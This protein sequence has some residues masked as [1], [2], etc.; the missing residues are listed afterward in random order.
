MTGNDEHELTDE[1]FAKIVDEALR[2]FP[3]VYHDPDT[4]DADPFWTAMFILSLIA[5]W[6]VIIWAIFV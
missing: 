4:Y 3:D 1:Q 6:V 5:I 2:R